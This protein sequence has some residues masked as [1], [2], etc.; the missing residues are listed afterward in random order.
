MHLIV[1]SQVSSNFPISLIPSSR[2]NDLIAMRDKYFKIAYESFTSLFSSE[3]EKSV[4]K[5]DD[6]F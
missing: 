5:Y 6:G 2:V 1:N 4:Y 3:K